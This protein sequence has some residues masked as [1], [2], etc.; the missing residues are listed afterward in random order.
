MIKHLRLIMLL[1]VSLSLTAC[2]GNNN[3]KDYKV[4]NIEITDNTKTENEQTDENNNIDSSDE[5]EITAKDE[6]SIDENTDENTE[7]IVNTEEDIDLNNG[8]Q[9]SDNWT[10]FEFAIDGVKIILPCTFEDLKNCGWILDRTR[11]NEDDLMFE[12]G[13][14][15]LGGIKLENENYPDV[16]FRVGI[17]NNTT[18][19]IDIEKCLITKVVIDKN[20]G[21]SNA[22]T[23][24]DV[25]LPK[26]IKWNATQEDVIAAFGETDDVY[27]SD[28]GGGYKIYRYT[29]DD[30][31]KLN[32]SVFENEMGFS[33]FELE[34]NAYT[35][36]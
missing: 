32:V 27:E 9:I 13:T 35:Y 7:E 3:H 6:V 18:E 17:I 31:H 23:Y 16:E 5:L 4:T 26:E 2:S 29:S 28:A 15:S 30:R 14:I 33:E 20:H 1:L 25:K 34:I 8:I 22:D 12:A 21:Y 11:Y 19:D 36:F 24:P 10:D